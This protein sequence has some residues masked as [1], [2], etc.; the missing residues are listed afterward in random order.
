[1]MSDCG[2]ENRLACILNL[3][4]SNLVEILIW[5]GFILIVMEK[6]HWDW[7]TQPDIV[8]MC[9]MDSHKLKEEFMQAKKGAN[10]S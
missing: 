5:V 1:M 8:N 6:Y 2:I 10:S 9:P 7:N 3:V 4:K